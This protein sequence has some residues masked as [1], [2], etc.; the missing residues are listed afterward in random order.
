ME[1][2]MGL[3]RFVFLTLI[4]LFFTYIIIVL[5]RNMDQKTKSSTKKRY[6]LQVTSGEQFLGVDKDHKFYIPD[7][8]YIG[9]NKQNTIILDDPYSSNYHT[10][11]ER[12]GKKYF[13]SD[14]DSKNGTQLN[15]INVTK[16]APLEKGDKIQIGDVI[17]RFDI[18]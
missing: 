6:H 12:K 2:F 4:A 18:D 1:I 15:D 13:I 14:M 10:L 17:F 5:N 16:N 9:R 11:I 7:Q 3:I 8:C